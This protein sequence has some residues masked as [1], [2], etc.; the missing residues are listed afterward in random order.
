MPGVVPGIHVLFASCGKDVD[1]RE[2]M[3]TVS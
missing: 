2:A 1:G 3:T